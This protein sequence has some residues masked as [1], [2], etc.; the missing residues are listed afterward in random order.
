MF[1]IQC[2]DIESVTT[3]VKMDVHV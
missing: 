3:I 1:N 2:D